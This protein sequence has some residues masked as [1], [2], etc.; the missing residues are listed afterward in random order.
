MNVSSVTMVPAAVGAGVSQ[1]RAQ[2]TP[3]AAGQL[4]EQKPVAMDVRSAAL[5]L[6]Q[7][8]L[9]VVPGAPG[10]DLDVTA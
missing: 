8:A 5:A 9:S 3:V 10:H 2:A 4:K 6:I 7:R 1:V